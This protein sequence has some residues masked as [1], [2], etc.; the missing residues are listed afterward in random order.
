[1]LASGHVIVHPPQSNRDNLMHCGTVPLLT[2]WPD[3]N[4]TF[5]WQVQSLCHCQWR[6]FHGS[7]SCIKWSSLPRPA[8]A[9]TNTSHR[10]KVDG[11]GSLHLSYERMKT[12]LTIRQF[13]GGCLT[14]GDWIKSGNG[15]ALSKV[16]QTCTLFT[17]NVT[18]KTKREGAFLFI[19]FKHLKRWTKKFEHM[20]NVPCVPHPTGMN[21]PQHLSDQKSKFRQEMLYCPL[22]LCCNCWPKSHQSTWKAFSNFMWIMQSKLWIN[23]RQHWY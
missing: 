10:F 14:A 2:S 15:K 9:D 12:N 19:E 3:K 6:Q 13:G 5:G 20:R 11:Y 1:M 7:R 21:V 22:S 18:V 16:C 17:E 4:E 23:K 8:A